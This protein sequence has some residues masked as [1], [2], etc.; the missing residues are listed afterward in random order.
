MA[1]DDIMDALSAWAD[2]VAA[3]LK[4]DPPTAEQINQLL[5][6]AGVAAHEV[7]RPAAPITT[8]LAGYALGADPSL[9]LESVVATITR[10]AKERES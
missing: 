10:L 8:F 3:D 9:S 6:V 4:I 5:G 2:K 1:D 7:L